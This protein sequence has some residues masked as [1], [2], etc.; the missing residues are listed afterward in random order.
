ML[1]DVLVYN[2]VDYILS[3]L[4]MSFLLRYVQY[5]YQLLKDECRVELSILILPA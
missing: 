5:V 3:F 1:D 4:T 2:L